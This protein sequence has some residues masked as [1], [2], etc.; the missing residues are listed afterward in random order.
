MVL[1]IRIFGFLFI[2]LACTLLLA[3]RFP[4]V[5]VSSGA[6]F[7]C[8]HTL[9]GQVRCWGNNVFGQAQP[10]RGDFAQVSAGWLHAC[11]VTQDSQ[12]ICWGSNLHGQTNVSP[13][14]FSQIS[15]GYWHTCGLT[16]DGR[17]RC[18][19]DDRY[20]QATV[21]ERTEQDFFVQVS[22]GGYFTCA[23]T[24]QGEPIC[25]GDD[26]QGQSSPP[27]VAFSELSAGAEHACGITR[28]TCEVYCWGY[29][30]SQLDPSMQSSTTTVSPSDAS[31]TQRGTP[32]M[33]I[34]TGAQHSCLLTLD[35]AAHCWGSN[36]HGQL[37]APVN[38]AFVQVSAGWDHTCGV[39]NT[40][41]VI[42]WGG[43]GNEEVT[44]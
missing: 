11:A 3:F 5:Q 40:G 1:R 13:G 39:T 44:F 26:R 20:G 18:W 27:P 28:D 22:A 38:V 15:A 4:V 7:A 24:R 16:L 23:L 25:W 41:Q 8:E 31:L 21:P 17:I 29:R 37:N 10:P 43:L 36:S 35:G 19:G 6:G 42:C 9:E 33:G 2:A 30:I 12:A 32:A 34:A 14:R